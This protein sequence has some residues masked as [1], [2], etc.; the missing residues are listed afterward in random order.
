[1]YLY[2]NYELE[3]TNIL[4]MNQT[5]LNILKKTY[6]PA[7]S[8]LFADEKDLIG[9][10][11]TYMVITEWDSLKDEGLLYAQRLKKAGVNVNLKFYENGFHGIISL[12]DHYVGYELARKMLDELI[13]YLKENI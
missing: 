9:L 7:V 10:P 13:D 12:I 6:D 1:M 3:E 11:K 5:Y 8:P 2:P 4:K